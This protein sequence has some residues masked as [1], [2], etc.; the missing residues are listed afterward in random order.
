M[1]FSPDL[2][3]VNDPSGSQLA[4]LSRPRPGSRAFGVDHFMNEKPSAA[5]A[6]HTRVDLED[7][8]FWRAGAIAVTA[9]MIVVLAFLSVD[10][11][12]VISVGGA[13]VPTYDVINHKIGYEY[14]W[15]RQMDVPT[16]GELDP[17]FG[18]VVSEAEAKALMDTGKLVIQSRNCMNCHTIFGNGAYYG[19]DLTKSWLDPAWH[20]IWMPMTGKSTQEEAMVEF[21]MHPDKYPTWNRRMPNLNIDEDEARA[22]V[23]YLKWLSSIDTNGF[24]AGFGRSVPNGQ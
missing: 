4:H 14:D 5:R 12:R 6:R 7:P 22:T 20:Q 23:A 1:L 18:K 2:I 17:L 8:L 3:L 16:I 21:L 9:V 15:S 24:P 13:N 10:S 19:P 11:M